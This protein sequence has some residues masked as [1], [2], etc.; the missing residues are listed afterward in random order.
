MY[1]L[2]VRGGRV[3]DGTGNPWFAGDIGVTGD[4]IAAIGNLD[5]CKADR[6]I[7]AK[8][9]A[10]AP[11]FIDIHTHSDTSLLVDSRGES[12]VRQGVTTAVI[13]NCGTS[14]APIASEEQLRRQLPPGFPW[15][16]KSYAEYLACVEEAGTSMNIVPLV[17]HGT[18]RNSVMG[19]DSDKPS[20]AQLEEMAGL[21]R[22][23]MEDGCF[24]I[25]TGLIY[26]PGCYG[27]TSEI[28]SLAK[29]AAEYGGLY[30]T[31]IRG[32]N[33]TLLDA[34]AE[35]IEVGRQSG[36]P[37][38]IAHLKAM[39]SHMWGTS[40]KVLRMIDQARAEG[41][42]VTFD[43]YP[44][45]ASATGLAATLPPWAQSGGR[46]K[47][48]ERLKDP[49]TRARM[50]KDMENGVDGWFSLLKGVGW[51]KILITNCQNP[52]WIGK[53]VAEI[54]AAQ[55][56][57]GFD[58]CFDL[59]LD[60]GGLVNIVFFN[61][62]D[63]DLERIMRHPAGMVGSDSSSSAVDGALARGKPHPRSYGTFVRVLGHY[64][65]DKGV[66]SLEEAIR[67]MTA[68]PSRKLRL[69]DRGLLRSGMKAD[70]VVFDP[71]TV[72]DRATYLNPFQYAEGVSTVVVNGRITVA[73]GQNTG[74]KAGQVL[75]RQQVRP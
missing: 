53:S 70:I 5:G 59:L 18:V 30:F 28:V 4:R 9:M 14:A 37:V 24:G 3:Y 55:G 33:D 41:I 65:R 16:W 47:F 58:A 8:G 72:C 50:R 54:A 34:V 62:G 67:K 63:E 48:M 29:V 69:W 22:Q 45:T 43:Q 64:V 75:R 7:N 12:H 38:Q 15:R 20:A 57:D 44:Y 46:E 66:I 1:S 61:I 27:D 60:N 39:G 36:A 10:V 32:E 49:G 31:H 71:E 2:I 25:S 42:E 26:T 40:F 52:E 17:G 73:D 23:A 35:A 11:G 6:V 21:V 51:D 68:M 19:Y 74:E 13:G 56:K